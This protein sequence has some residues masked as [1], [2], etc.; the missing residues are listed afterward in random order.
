MQLARKL[1][2]FDP[3]D[4]VDVGGQV[5]KQRLELPAADDPEREV[6]RSAGCGK[7][8]LDAL[9]RDQLADEQAGER[10]VRS[11]ARLEETLLGSDEADL[12]SVRR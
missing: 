1:L 10:F 3:A 9:E 6:R 8:R 12:H 5:G 4:P 11:P 2:V 7:D